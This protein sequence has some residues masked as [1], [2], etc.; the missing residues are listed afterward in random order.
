MQAF[1]FNGDAEEEPAHRGRGHPHVCWFAVDNEG[2]PIAPLEDA[3]GTDL[4][5]ARLLA[6][7]VGHDQ[8]SGGSESS[9]GQASHGPGEGG[10]AALHVGRSATVE[11]AVRD[12]PAPGIAAQPLGPLLRADLHRVGV[13]VVH[14]R[15]ARHASR[16]AHHRGQIRLVRGTIPEIELIKAAESRRVGLVAT[17]AP[18]ACRPALRQSPVPD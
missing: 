2:G 12:V 10:V 15:S 14:Q 1:A 18:L 4:G 17:P 5:L 7:A 11:L 8:I 13:A 3:Q 16:A 9:R 6:D